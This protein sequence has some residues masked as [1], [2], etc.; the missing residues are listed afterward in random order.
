MTNEGTLRKMDK[1]PRHKQLRQND[2][3]KSDKKKK[4]KFAF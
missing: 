2:R 3:I 4:C 1:A